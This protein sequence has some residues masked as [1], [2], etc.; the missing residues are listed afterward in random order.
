MN[1]TLN[2]FDIYRTLHPTKAEYTFFLSM[3]TTF[4]KIE[5]MLAHKTSFNKLQ[6]IK[7][8]E[9]KLEIS[10]VKEGISLQILQT[11]KA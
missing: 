1:N 3:Y 7:K 8:R 2:L 6:R 9:N 10:G 5:H 11:L 4:T